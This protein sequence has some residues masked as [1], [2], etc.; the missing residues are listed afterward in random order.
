MPQMAGTV[1]V[2]QEGRLQLLD[3]GGA[4]HVFILSHACAAEPQQLYGLELGRTRLRIDYSEPTNVIGFLAEKIEVLN[5][6]IV[7]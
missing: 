3:D 7:K 4:G 5:E 1:V 2:V 6:E